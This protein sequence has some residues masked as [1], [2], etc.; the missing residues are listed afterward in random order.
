MIAITNQAGADLH[1]NPGQRLNIEQNGGWLADEEL[2]G[3]LSYPIGF[4]LSEHNNRFLEY[5]Y[6]PDHAR[7][8]MELPV[9]V[10]LDGVLYR[11]CTLSYRVSGGRGDG[12]LKID[13][14]EVYGKL[15]GMSLLDALPDV[16]TVDDG[17]LTN[18]LAQR[19]GEIA[20]LPPG[21]FPFTVFPIRNELFFEPDMAEKLTGFAQQPYVNAWSSQGAAPGSFLVDSGTVKG[22]PICPQFYLA[23]VLERIYAL[24]N[25]RIIGDWIGRAETQRLTV[26]N[27][28]TLARPTGIGAAFGNHRATAG[29]C[30]PDMSVTDF[31]KA[32]KQRYGLLF[33]FNANDQTVSIRRYVDVLKHP[34]RQD[35]SAFQLTGYSIEA[36]SNLGFSI[37][38][39]I[40]PSDELYRDE[41]GKTIYPAPIRVGK[42]GQPVDMKVGSTQMIYEKTGTTPTAPYRK[43]PTVRQAGNLLDPIYKDSD[44]YLDM[45]GGGSGVRRNDVG[46]RILSYRGLVADSAGALYPLGASDERDGR[47]AVIA[48]AESAALPGRAGVYR[49]SLRQYYYFRD[50]TRRV[51]EQLLL[52]VAVL[53]SLRFDEPVSLTLDDGIRRSYLPD[54]LEADSAGPSGLVNAKLTMYTL[55]D[56]IDQPADIDEP[57]VWI[58]L[59]TVNRTIP[60]GLNGSTPQNG[61]VYTTLTVK[62][63]ANAAKTQAAVV[64]NLEI[65]LRFKRRGDLLGNLTGSTYVQLPYVET[66]RTYYAS[67]S[68]SVIESELLTLQVYGNDGQLSIF[69]YSIALDPG[70]GYT[71]LPS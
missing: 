55:P 34:T 26:L 68:T 29:M 21:Q 59:V 28:T 51:S 70:E 67:G 61:R 66:V 62:C 65:K 56:G 1:L 20:R 14:G 46:L 17:L 53:A 36:A 45:S 63:W 10:G 52:P 27:L 58:E 18:T 4:P 43:L 9:T 3:A 6:R 19:L 32:I 5:A 7:P 16:V 42:G 2:P 22:R 71:I 41:K 33:T 64:N 60:G 23:W 47:Q 30:L 40:D 12:F 38:E 49:N 50:Q 44:R 54:K 48:G 11:R 13:G 8:E 69:Q 15:R 24:V 57:M 31:L 25:Y 37:E 39:F 35:L